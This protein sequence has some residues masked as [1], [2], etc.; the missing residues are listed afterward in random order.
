[1]T[2]THRIKLG[3]G[4]WES[5]L[6]LETRI[7]VN[8]GNIDRRTNEADVQ[9]RNIG[10]INSYITLL[11]DNGFDPTDQG[12]VVEPPP[13]PTP[14]PPTADE[15]TR[16]S[17]VATAFNTVIESEI[18]RIRALVE[19]EYGNIKTTNEVFL[20]KFDIKHLRQRAR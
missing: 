20:M 19:T 3:N 12:N 9:A 6:R 13:E 15:L 8:V 2:I 1:M 18:T 7:K 5:A 17:E 11:T 10:D 16:D 4:T 14:P